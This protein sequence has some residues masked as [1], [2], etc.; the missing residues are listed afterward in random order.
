[1]EDNYSYYTRIVYLSSW[2][3]DIWMA[4]SA[5]LLLSC[6][7]FFSFLSFSFPFLRAVQLSDGLDG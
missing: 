4:F 1:M 3:F 2:K 5:F 7:A 6:V